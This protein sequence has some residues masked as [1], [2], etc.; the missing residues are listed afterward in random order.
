[1]LFFSFL[2]SFKTEADPLRFSHDGEV[3]TCQILQAIELSTLCKF[4]NFSSFLA[5][6]S[7]Y[8]CPNTSKR[9]FFLYL[10]FFLSTCCFPVFFVEVI[11]EC[12]FFFRFVF[13][14]MF[15]SVFIAI[16]NF[17]ALTSL[18]SIDDLTGSTVI[19]LIAHE[20]GKKH[21]NTQIHKYRS[22]KNTN[23]QLRKNTITWPD[24]PSFPL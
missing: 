10:S 19:P 20:A 23:I 22:T 13:C 7:R 15:F 18:L 8:A 5:T 6:S 3:T 21:R 9:I 14:F 12:I 2:S 4:Q 16:G 17:P 11:P 24:P 1:M